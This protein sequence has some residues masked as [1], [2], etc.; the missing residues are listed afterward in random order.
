MQ[1]NFRRLKGKVVTSG[2]YEDKNQGFYDWQ[3]DSALGMFWTRSAA[4]MRE[5]LDMM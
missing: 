5:D 1:L 2:F 3:G 4:S